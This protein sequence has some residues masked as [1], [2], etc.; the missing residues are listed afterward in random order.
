VRGERRRT[1]GVSPHAGRTYNPGVAGIELAG[2]PECYIMTGP[3]T[4]GRSH[5]WISDIRSVSVGYENEGAKRNAN[6]RANLGS[7][8]QAMNFDEILAFMDEFAKAEEV[9][10]KL[11]K[12]KSDLG[13]K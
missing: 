1:T 12:R 11:E 2:S 9:L 3:Q 10:G 5:K 13:L 6:I 7:F 4:G 8:R